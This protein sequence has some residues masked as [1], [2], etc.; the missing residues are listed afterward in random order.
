MTA[1]K[2][3]DFQICNLTATLNLHSYN[4]NVFIAIQCLMY[5]KRG[6]DQTR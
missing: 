1:S 6:Q 4:R 2:I 3:E 5:I